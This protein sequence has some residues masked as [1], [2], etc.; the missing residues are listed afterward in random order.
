M[1]KIIGL[2][3]FLFVL[4]NFG[5]AGAETDLKLPG[6][7]KD[8]QQ[9]VLHG[10]EELLYCV[11]QFDA[12]DKRDCIWPD[13]LNINVSK[14]KGTFNYSVTLNKKSWVQVP[15]DENSWPLGV[16]INGKEALVIVFHGQPA[17]LLDR[18][19]Y[20]IAGK[21]LW[22]SRPDRIKIPSAAVF[23]SAV[24]DGEARK[25]VSIDDSSVLWL[26][27]G[28]ETG[29]TKKIENR[30]ELQV[31]RLI[32]DQIPARIQMQIDLQISGSRREINLGPV[33]A[34]QFIPVSLTSTLPAKIE[35]NN[36]IIKARPGRHTVNLTM[37]MRTKLDKISFAFPPPPWPSEEIWSIRS[38]PSLR[39]IKITGAPQIDPAQTT[40]P[41]NW[42]GLP[43][44]VLHSDQK[45]NFETVRRGEEQALPDKLKIDREFGLRYDGNSITARDTI[46]GEKNS[47]WRIEVA[48]GS[49]LAMV[50][51]NGENQQITKRKGAATPGFEV[52]KGAVE[53]VTES[54]FLAENPIK[55][56]GW[57]IDPQRLAITLNIPPG[58]QLL[59]ATGAEN[60]SGSWLQK[61]DLL[62]IFFLLITTLSA[63]KLFGIPAA[64]VNFTVIGLTIHD[65]SAPSVWL[66]LFLY[67][68]YAL[69]RIVPQNAKLS[70]Y[71]ARIHF[72]TLILVIIISIPY[73]INE[74]RT[75]IYPQLKGPAQGYDL[76][77]QQ[78]A[79]LK[80][81]GNVAEPEKKE[82]GK[83]AGLISSA[84]QSML[85]DEVDKTREYAYREKE[86]L[87]YDPKAL[88]NVGTGFPTWNFAR[89]YLSWSGPVSQQQSIRLIFI[90]PAENLILAF[91]K[92]IA[93]LLLLFLISGVKKIDLEPLRKYGLASTALL[94]GVLFFG[95]P[96]TNAAEI[97]PDHLLKELKQR[98]LEPERCFESRCAELQ[99]LTLNE[100]EDQSLRFVLR[101]T[102][103]AEVAVPLPA[104]PAQWIPH[105]ISLLTGG[106]PRKFMAFR[107]GTRIWLSLPKGASKISFAIQPGQLSTIQVNMP[108]PPHLVVNNL[109]T[110]SVDGIDKNGIP[111]ETMV[112]RRQGKEGG[113]EKDETFA[114][115]IFP[116]F[117]IVEREIN[118]GL[119]WIATTTVQR[120]APAKAGFSLTIPL[121]K[122]ESVTT[123]GLTVKN[124]EI[125]VNFDQATQMVSWSSSIEKQPALKLVHPRTEAY[126]EI[127]SVDPS[128]IWHIEYQGLDPIHNK[129]NGTWLPTWHPYPGES[130]SLTITK[131]EGVPGQLIAIDT[132][133][134]VV[135]PGKRITDFKLDFPLRSHQGGQ[136][137]IKLPQ[138]I[139]LQSVLINDQSYPSQ[140]KDGQLVLPVKPGDQRVAIEWRDEK[141]V[142]GT[143]YTV[144]KIDLGVPSV[145][146]NINLQV[147]RDRWPLLT[148]GPRSGPAV[149]YWSMLLVFA[150]IAFL[151]GRMAPVPL[152]ALSWFLL[153]IGLSQTSIVGA[154]IVVGWL[155]LLGF[156]SRYTWYD[157]KFFN[158]VQGLI[159][160]LTVVSF[161]TLV[162][163]I[164][165]GLLGS[166]DMLVSG[167]G[168]S[169]YNLRWYQDFT[170]GPLPQPSLISV[171]MFVYRFLML[172]WSTWISFTLLRL[173]KWGWGCFSK[174]RVWNKGRM[175]KSKAE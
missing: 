65:P 103:A 79:K 59:T 77:R 26:A 91:V 24:I 76:S 160:F 163:S 131:P 125:T 58:Y 99:E 20:R 142:I 28:K 75:G 4:L 133:K 149:L 148:F 87:Q 159:I 89:A 86:N 6:A 127:W 19:F 164:S 13:E 52:R 140:L 101:A 46:S 109:K 88:V 31:F 2:A 84:P 152:S 23:V 106:T 70:K 97:P 33:I 60:I 162:F 143:K 128:A 110:W 25:N 135:K 3:A 18:G 121:L 116:H 107:D 105:Q 67:A 57:K 29:E 69:E 78:P 48:D 126:T 55:A 156:R 129:R 7:L 171:P 118:F 63:F 139:S 90:G 45:L 137:A 144:P 123:E 108:L 96:R 169:T 42:Q 175:W 102:A 170:A 145:N 50:S 39:L 32:D 68:V 36:L 9:W 5:S 82:A 27:K 122:G 21:F 81:A 100:T 157:S 117:A 51:L 104:Y 136:H 73:I 132:S 94:V 150:G 173:V 113:E 119:E 146:A 54:H 53:A 30:V 16:T 44:Y 62:K 154:A 168:S 166:P 14:N 8:W 174:D 92:T 161:F 74:V 1:R 111:G 93:L 167:N 141:T 61:W 11:P 64:L 172:A 17:I 155:I 10:E 165:Q 98:L 158:V 66:W 38:Q 71:L 120:V 95:I 49:E 124:G 85:S 43:A 72:A 114:A 34:E 138:G 112:L 47:D 80:M 130:V 41:K 134:L 151:L 56:T 153:A 12:S 115:G 22:V 147:G 83:V 15:G 35:A 40:M 37:R